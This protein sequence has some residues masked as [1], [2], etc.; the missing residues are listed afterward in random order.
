L[1]PRAIP[2]GAKEAN[3]TPFA[4]ERLPRAPLSVA[5]R[6]I[7]APV[8]HIEPIDATP[9][10][11]YPR[12][13]DLPKETPAKAFASDN[14]NGASAWNNH[15]V[16]RTNRFVRSALYWLAEEFLRHRTGGVAGFL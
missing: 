10:A 9:N 12:A 16:A 13:L 6:S 5:A 7:T 3:F 2:A 15:M 1:T 11:N 14:S 4:L 8:Q